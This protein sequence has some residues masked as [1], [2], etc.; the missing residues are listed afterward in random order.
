MFTVGINSSQSTLIEPTWCL[1]Y[2]FFGGRSEEEGARREEG[3]EDERFA[4]KNKDV[5]RKVRKYDRRDGRSKAKVRALTVYGDS[6]IMA[7][8]VFRP[9]EEGEG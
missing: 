6:S 2:V 7:Y 9:A 5:R 4:L 3:R 1:R 8:V